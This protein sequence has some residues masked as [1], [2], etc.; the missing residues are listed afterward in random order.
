[1]FKESIP[2]LGK[3]GCIKGGLVHIHVQKPSEKDVVVQHLAEEPIGTDGVEGY[4]KLG[5]K[6]ALRGNGGPACIAVH[7]VKNFRKLLKGPH[8]HTL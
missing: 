4:E 6:K 7:G 8:R 3:G 1:M 5:F 2:I